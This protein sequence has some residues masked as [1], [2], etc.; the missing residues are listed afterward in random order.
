MTM[1]RITTMRTDKG[2]DDDS[3]EGDEVNATSTSPSNK[4][5]RYNTITPGNNDNIRGGT[6][7]KKY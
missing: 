4:K 3:D 5:C 6:H 1:T 2:D 7:K